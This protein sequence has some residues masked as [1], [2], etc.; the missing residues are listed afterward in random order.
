MDGHPARPLDARDIL[1]TIEAERITH[2]ALVEPLLVELI[3]HPEFG[4]RDLSSLVA[5]SHIGADAAPALR[6]R[7][8]G[9]C[10]PDP[11]AP[12]G[13]SE[14]GIVSVLAEALLAG[15]SQASRHRRAPALRSGRADRASGRQR[16][17]P[18]R[19][20]VRHRA[21]TSGGRG[22]RR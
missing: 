11:G 3:D 14:T 5:I 15:S 2:L 17:A 16:G 4:M 19:G 18:R 1:A 8:L 13:A 21:I 10:G 9:P 12:Y 6:Q 7:L 20:G 22:V